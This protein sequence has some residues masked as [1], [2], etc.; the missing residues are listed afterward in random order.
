MYLLDL[1]VN[2]LTLVLIY[3]FLCT[4]RQWILNSRAI[5]DTERRRDFCRRKYETDNNN[6]SCGSQ[7]FQTSSGALRWSH[8][9]HPHSHDS[10]KAHGIVVFAHGF[11]M[12]NYLFLPTL[13][14]LLLKANLSLYAID[15]EAHGKSDG[16]AGY[17]S[18]SDQ[19]ILELNEYYQHVQTQ[20][21]HKQM[22]HLPVFLFGFSMGAS[23]ILASN[24]KPWKQIQAM[25]LVS[26]F[27]F[28]WHE[29]LPDITV[30]GLQHCWRHYG[31]KRVART[32][33]SN[34]LTKDIDDYLYRY[35]LQ[36]PNEQA[37]TSS[38]ECEVVYNGILSWSS[39][40]AMKRLS[41]RLKYLIKSQSVDINHLLCMHGEWDT[42]VRAHN[43][44]WIGKSIRT[45]GSKS[46][47][48]CSQIK[49]SVL[50][51][52]EPHD[53]DAILQEIVQWIKQHLD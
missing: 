25:I 41:D 49:H 35:D 33:L 21:I 42:L 29:F 14:P 11:A 20:L 7:F 27:I 18:S 51:G 24:Y 30:S 36:V 34:H 2:G 17:L 8:E 45:H 43:T 32:I 50:F 26:P 16:L 15:F 22:D 53:Q 5:Q 6:L 9:Y 38:Q 46:I 23:T 4:I 39:C 44:D 52:N 10:N 31:L 1:L 3:Y 37:Y 47:R 48:I 28:Q 12:N 13:L 19:L 40:M